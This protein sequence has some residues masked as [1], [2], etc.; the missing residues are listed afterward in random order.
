MNK[1]ITLLLAAAMI[2]IKM[3]SQVWSNGQN[4]HYA[5]A[6]TS[7]SNAGIL[8]TTDSTFTSPVAQ[9]YVAADPKHKCLYVSDLF[10]HRILR[11]AYPV[12][13]NMPVANLVIGQPN[14]TTAVSNNGGITASSLGYPGGLAIDSV[15]GTLWVTDFLNNRVLRYDSA[16]NITS[17]FAN[18][19]AVLGQSSFTTG[20]GS[21]TQN[22]I[23]F[24]LAPQSGGLI[25]YDHNT[26]ALWVSDNL[27]KRVLRYNNAATKPSGANADAVLG[28]SVFTTAF[29]GLNS[30]QFARPDGLTTV[31]TS[32]FV[33]DAPNNR[34]L[35]FD[36]V[37]AKANGAAADAVLGQVNFTSNSAA[38]SATSLSN[39]MGLSSDGSLLYLNDLGN[40]RVLIFNS[41]ITNTVANNVLLSANLTTAGSGAVSPSTGGSNS[42]IFIEPAFKQLFVQDRTNKRILVFNGCAIPMI[43]GTSSVC[44]GSSATLTASGASTYSWNTGATSTNIVVS[45][46]VTSVYTVVAT[47]TM[48]CS[49]SNS[50]QFSVNVTPLP[51]LTLVSTSSAICTGQ[52]A[53][54][55]VNGA[56][57]YSWN[58]GTSSASIVVSPS[59]ATSYTVTGTTSGCAKTNTMILAVNSNPTVSA[60]SSSSLVCVGQPSTLTAIGA[61]TYSWSNGSTNATTVITPTANTNYS[62][63]GTNSAGCSTSYSITQAVSPCTGVEDYL[64][65]EPR[66]SIYPNP[67]N[68]EFNLKLTVAGGD[69]K[70]EIVNLLGELVYQMQPNTLNIKVDIKSLIPGIYIIKVLEKNNM[71]FKANIIKQ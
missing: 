45:P 67:N 62:V 51:T 55:S 54:L 61:V 6:A 49:I 50:L 7:L 4:A 23:S 66:V 70:V 58:T 64:T 19:S 29:T 15:S 27:N 40:S 43:T 44:A 68:G 5:F 11:F 41:A 60:V 53:T 8:S 47:T 20:G 32:L 39:P 69:V 37:Y 71:V 28:Q 46:S 63:V 56:A 35:R 52:T 22:G 24:D 9:V 2:I 12:I 36:N 26:G 59:I 17:N 13:A 21:T 14:F 16:F 65:A 34:V 38:V 48:A 3:H 31:G 30:S 57:S 18:A 10:G 25:H 33:S 42:A 1:K